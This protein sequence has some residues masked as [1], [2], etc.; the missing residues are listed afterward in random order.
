M[1]DEMRRQRNEQASTAA[2]VGV[3]Q[4]ALSAAQQP[5]HISTH[6]RELRTW[7]G[8]LCALIVVRGVEEDSLEPPATLAALTGAKTRCRR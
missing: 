8:V 4:L 5:R 7:M 2:R 3:R 6:R 1:A